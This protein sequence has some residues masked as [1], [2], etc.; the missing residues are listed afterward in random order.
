MG[1][2]KKSESVQKH[3]T[4]RLT[5]FG[6]LCYKSR[7]TVHES[8]ERRRLRTDLIMCYKI[9]NSGA[10]HVDRDNLFVMTVSSGADSMGHG[11]TCPPLAQMAGHGGTVSRRTANKKLTKLY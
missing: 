7:L 10:V 8:L 6:K 3:F 5:S 4:K 9:F 2:I 1:Y 11:G